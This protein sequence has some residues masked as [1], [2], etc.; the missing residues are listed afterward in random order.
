MLLSLVVC[1]TPSAPEPEHLRLNVKIPIYANDNL[2][3][4]SGS[5]RRGA[6]PRGGGL[7]GIGWFS[8]F[9]VIIIMFAGY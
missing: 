3:H 2:Y 6:L 4:L 1:C 8:Y 9:I 7:A 5:S